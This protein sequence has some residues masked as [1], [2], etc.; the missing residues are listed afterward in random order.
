MSKTLLVGTLALVATG[1]TNLSTLLNEPTYK[2]PEVAPQ[3][4]TGAN[5]T[6]DKFVNITNSTDVTIC[7]LHVRMNSLHDAY[8]WSTNH[9]KNGPTVTIAPGTTVRLDTYAKGDRPDVLA[10]DCAGNP[11]MRVYEKTAFA[12][13]D[14]ATWVIER[15]D[16]GARADV[17]K[18]RGIK[19]KGMWTYQ[20]GGGSSIISVKLVNNCSTNVKY[21]RQTPSSGSSHGNAYL[22]G[23]T[24]T[25]INVDAGDQITLVDGSTCGAAVFTVT[26]Q[27]NG[28][29]IVLCK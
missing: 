24:S 15:K 10:K 5:R 13:V 27:S 1:C 19:Q 23:N 2:A 12:A 16:E 21:C 7:A 9:L 17:Q 29:E 11:V 18:A 26:A 6:G 22:S 28:Q 14:G 4:E 20:S 3:T 8:A 25:S